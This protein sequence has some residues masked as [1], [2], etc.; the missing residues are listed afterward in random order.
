MIRLLVVLLI[1][2]VGVYWGALINPNVN[3]LDRETKITETI[4]KEDDHQKEWDVTEVEQQL[5]KEPK[6]VE[7]TASLFEKIII[8][9]YEKL[10]ALLFYIANL[11]FSI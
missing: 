4:V 9:F 11:L 3:Q 7:K 10:V 2:G 6:L 5:I 1:F 8:F